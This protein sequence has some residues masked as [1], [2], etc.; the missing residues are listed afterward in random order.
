M[1]VMGD[2]MRQELIQMSLPKRD[3][4][5]QAIPSDCPHQPLTDGVCLERRT[6]VFDTR[7]PIAVTAL[8]KSFDKMLH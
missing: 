7:T 4:E 1:I 3:Q 5:V 8:S 2:P 6:G